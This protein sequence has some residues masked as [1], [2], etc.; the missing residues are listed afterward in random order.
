[1]TTTIKNAGAF[2]LATVA[3][4]LAALTLAGPASAHAMKKMEAPAA[5]EQM[6]VGSPLD[7]AIRAS[8]GTDFAIISEAQLRNGDAAVIQETT[9]DAKLAAIHASITANPQLARKITA[10]NVE[11]K[12]ITGA[13]RAADG[14][15][16]F[17]TM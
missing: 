17:Y 11:V 10:Q 3:A 2:T 7:Q 9:S 1:M 12:E 6:P 15:L 16:I 13:A 5:A 14:S 4:G 8:H